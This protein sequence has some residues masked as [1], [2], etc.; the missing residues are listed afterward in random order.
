MRKLLPMLAVSL[1]VVAS[2]AHAGPRP[3]PTSDKEEAQTTRCFDT[4]TAS[5]C[6]GERS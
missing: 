6:T 4:A 5:R 1:S 3:L 2:A